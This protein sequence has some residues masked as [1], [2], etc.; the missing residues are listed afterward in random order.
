MDYGGVDGTLATAVG[1]EG[2]LWDSGVPGSPPASTSWSNPLIVGIHPAASARSHVIMSPYKIIHLRRD[3]CNMQ[4][5]ITYI[6]WFI[7]YFLVSVS[8]DPFHIAIMSSISKFGKTG[9]VMIWRIMMALSYNFAHV[10]VAELSWGAKMWHDLTVRIIT[11][12]R[13]L[14]WDFNHELINALERGWLHFIRL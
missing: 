11:K 10:T 14:S 1:G 13:R 5:Q 9:I 4:I 12:S 3:L 2:C 8:W 7:A 6:T